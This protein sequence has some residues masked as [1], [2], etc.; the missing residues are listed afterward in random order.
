MREPW[1]ILYVLHC[2]GGGGTENGVVNLLNR[3]DPD[4]FRFT[5]VLLRAERELLDRIERPGVDVVTV[6][7]K[8]GNDPL[9]VLRMIRTIRRARPDLVHT[10]G[11]SCI[12]S[13]AAARLAGVRAVVHGEHGRDADEADA[14][15]PRRAALRSFLYRYADQVVTVSA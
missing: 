4:R 9:H 8:W 12:E 2:L 15:K 1:H 6:A 10:R 5:L 3:A 13:L 7:R 11:F 14:M